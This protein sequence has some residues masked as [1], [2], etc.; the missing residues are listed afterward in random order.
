MVSCM[1]FILNS[2]V[3]YVLQDVANF[4]GGNIKCFSENWYKYIRHPNVLEM[5]SSQLKLEL[6]QMSC[7]KSVINTS[8]SKSEVAIIF[9]E[10]TKFL[11]KEVIV[12]S[13]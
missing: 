1:S 7:Q 11:S 10:I 6:K 2:L 13:Y 5:V 9:E 12:E 3:R 8:L 4:R